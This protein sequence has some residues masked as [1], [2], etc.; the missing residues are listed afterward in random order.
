MSDEDD[1]LRKRINLTV[2]HAEIKSWHKRSNMYHVKLVFEGQ[3]DFYETWEKVS[4]EMR[5]K[6]LVLH[7][8][9][10]LIDEVQ[11]TLLS[12]AEKENQLLKDHNRAQQGRITELAQ[13]LEYANQTIATQQQELARLKQLEVEVSAVA[14][15]LAQ[16]S[17]TIPP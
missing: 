9:P 4:A 12:D 15:L 5:K 10:G 2:T 11:A 3:T 13:Q 16:A 8:G 6:G 1:T 7:D 17:G 14:L